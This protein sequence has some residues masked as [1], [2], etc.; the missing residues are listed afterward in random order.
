MQ[1]SKDQQ[2]V[3]D[4]RGRNLLVSAA[5]GSGKTAVL[6]ERILSLITDEKKRVDLDRILVVTFTVAAAGEMKDRIGAALEKRLEQDPENEYLQ[7]QAVLIHHAQIN[8]IHS[9]C[10]YIIRNYFY[11]IDM[12]PVFRVMEDAERKLLFTDVLSGLLEER[13]SRTGT[14]ES[15]MDFD[16]L[17]NNWFEG[18]TDAALEDVLEALYDT[19]VTTPWPKRWLSQAAAA[20]EEE[21][22]RAE[23]SQLERAAADS[24]AAGTEVIGN[25]A[26]GAEVIGSEAAGAEVI[27]SEEA[28]AEVIGS[29][30]AAGS[31]EKGTEAAGRGTEVCREKRLE[32]NTR[33][34]GA[35][36]RTKEELRQNL[37][38][39]PA[40]RALVSLTGELIDRFDAKKREKGVCDFSDLEHLALSILYEEND[41]GE[42]VR[43]DAAKELAARF[44]YV[45]TDEY[46]DSNLIQEAIL[47]A[48]SGN[49]DGTFNRFMVGDIKQSIYGFR[50]ARPDIFL[51][52]YHTYPTDQEEE[53]GGTAAAEQNAEEDGAAAEQNAEEDGTAAEQNAEKDGAAAAKPE[54]TEK[55]QKALRIDLHTN[56]RSRREVTDTVNAVFSRL[57]I[58]ELGGISYDDAAALRYG[59]TYPEDGKITPAELILMDLKSPDLENH[60]TAAGREAE[61]L[62]VAERIRQIA[63]KMPVYDKEAGAE[64]PCRYSDIVLLFQV[65]GGVADI[66]ASVLTEQGIPCHTT[67]REGYF[68]ATEVVTILN[69]LSI[70]DNPVQ[71]IPFA[72][73]L[74]SPIVDLSSEDLAEIRAY[75]LRRKKE[76]QAAETGRMEKAQDQPGKDRKT[77]K[78][79]AD[80]DYYHACLQYEKDGPDPHLRAKLGEFFAMYQTLRAQSSYMPVHELMEN[81]YRMTGYRNIAAAMPAGEQRAANLDMLVTKAKKFEDTSYHGLFNFIRYVNRLQKYSVDEGEANL[82]SDTADAVRLM[83]IHKSKGLEFPVV[84]LCDTS[85]PFNVK[86]TGGRFLFHP[87]LG[88]GLDACDMEKHRLVKTTGRQRIADRKKEESYAENIRVLYVALTR[89]REKL[90]ITAMEP[91][92]EKMLS[93]LAELHLNPEEPVPKAVLLNYRRFSD[94]LILALCGTKFD[95]LQVKTETPTSV[96]D[97]LSKQD[98]RRGAF[99]EQL[100]DLDPGQVYDADVRRML[101]ETAEFRYPFGIPAGLP[102]KMTVTQLK[103]LNDE[104]SEEEQGEVFEKEPVAVPYLPAFASGEE[105]AA[106][107][108]AARGTIYHKVFE[109]IVYEEVPDGGKEAAEEY[110]KRLMQ[111]LVSGGFLKEAQAAAVRPKDI[112]GFL[113]S[114]IGRRMKE[115]ALAGNLK[116]EQAFTFSIPANEVDAAWPAEEELLVQGIIDAYF[117]E[118]GA[119][120]IVDYKTDFVPDD[121]ASLVDKYS[122][123]VYY[124]A[125]ALQAATGLEVKEKHIYSTFLGKSLPCQ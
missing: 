119:Y 69:V 77:E 102:G 108:G 113:L 125:R 13:Y 123:Q 3:I 21:S 41:S 51:E 46:Q 24:E 82:F 65:A 87:D 12:D 78:K 60:S 43:S 71:D 37:Y 15:G 124:Y 109:K 53:E 9:F 45:M 103:Y 8:T 30:P 11:R 120:V 38:C 40:V 33:T 31:E 99:F 67:S 19:A 52:K 61:A 62:I 26:P 95:F 98:K 14:E 101:K 29:G 4:S 39:A 117:L 44:E 72:A 121:G 2:K 66:F 110:V 7:H 93:D 81:I 83:T 25:E 85:H 118:D 97:K 17:V 104:M 35:S 74:F 107:S 28:R 63:G 42:M 34:D 55:N 49:E 70:L 47:H 57:M 20:Y 105:A 36:G 96:E 23:L 18:K 73:V 90:Y 58:P 16:F 10:S 115:A 91:D 59:G 89:A 64:R 22:L 106:V 6:V 94:W 48:V 5:A 92:L 122:R 84:F 100:A 88:I 114:P 68:S 75:D 112:A 56:Y 80:T 76:A 111:A 54:E 116:R 50:Q 27:G 86:D 32:T 1:F 79:S